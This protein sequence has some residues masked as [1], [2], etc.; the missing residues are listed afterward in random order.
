MIDDTHPS[1]FSDLVRISGFSHGTDVWLG[2][3]QDLIRNGQCT[4]REAISARDDI[5]MYL[6]HN[7]IDPL[8]SFQTMESVRKGKGIKEETVKILREGGIPEWYIEACQKIKYM[9]PRAHATAYVMMA[10]RIAYCKVHYPL[11]FYAAYFSIRAAEFDADVV[12]RGKDHVK[13]QLDTLEAKEVPDIKEK[14]TIIVLQLAWEMYLRGFSM[15]HVD[16]YASEAERFVLHEKSLLPPLASLGG[17]GISAARSIVEARKD[18][19]F[20]S[21]EDIKKRTG[22]SKTCIEALQAHGCLADLDASDQM[23]LFM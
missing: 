6:I 3:A 2:N 22:I 18:G 9:F 14:A 21:I 5:M 16:I 23:E 4:L 12:A 10:W 15:E 7:G 19:L 20:T 8:L 13:K 1:C 17:V 11:A